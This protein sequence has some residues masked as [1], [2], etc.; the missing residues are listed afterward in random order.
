[1]AAR[2]PFA[3]TVY[4]RE[5]KPE[6][7]KPTSGK[8]CKRQR[9]GRNILY[10]DIAPNSE[11]PRTYNLTHSGHGG[12]RKRKSN[13]R[14]KTISK[15]KKNS[16]LARER[17]CAAEDNAVDYD[18]RNKDAEARGERWQIRLHQKVHGRNERSYNNDVAR[19]VDGC[20]NYL[21]QRRNKHIR[22]NKNERGSKPHTK[23]ILKAGSHRQRRAQ[24]KNE[25][26]YR[27]I[28]YYATPKG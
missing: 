17:L 3:D 28:L 18:E 7:N 16:V 13:T 21:T 9:L 19:N 23:S 22:A 5:E 15:G 6:N 8:N 12:K 24:A 20:G 27:I 11:R 1:M 2:I 25:P 4:E 26:K 14:A 10:C